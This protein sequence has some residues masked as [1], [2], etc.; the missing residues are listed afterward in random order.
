MKKSIFG[1]IPFFP[2]PQIVLMMMI[3]YA[4]PLHSETVEYSYAGVSFGFPDTT[5]DLSASWEKLW[6]ARDLDKVI[7]LYQPDAEFITETG[8]RFSGI[9]SIRK[10]FKWALDSY[11]AN[12]KMRIVKREVLG[13]CA[14]ESGEFIETTESGSGEG[15]QI[16]KGSYLMVLKKNPAGTWLIAEQIWAEKPSE[17]KGK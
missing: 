4:W 16:L 10:I 13:N 17:E 15:R 14:Y 9:D 6:N 3:S 2:I 7:A 5:T 1:R 12:I 11:R 8:D